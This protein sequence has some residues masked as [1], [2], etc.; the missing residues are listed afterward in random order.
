[1]TLHVGYAE[2]EQDRHRV[3]VLDA[4][5]DRWHVTLRGCSDENANSLL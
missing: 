5:R 2:L 1:M 4:F 3:R